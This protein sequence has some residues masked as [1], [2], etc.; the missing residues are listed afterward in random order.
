MLQRT[1]WSSR[2][3]TGG[4]GMATRS[5]HCPLRCLCEEAG[6]GTLSPSLACKH[7]SQGLAAR[8]GRAVHAPELALPIQALV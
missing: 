2:R 1:A 3:R 8:Q 6:S 7:Q 5:L 4:L